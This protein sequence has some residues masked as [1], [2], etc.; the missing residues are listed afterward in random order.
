VIAEQIVADANVADARKAFLAALS[1]K[2]KPINVVVGD[3]IRVSG[4][5][6]DVQDAILLRAGSTSVKDATDTAKG[7]SNRTVIDMGRRYY[8]TLGISGLEDAGNTQIAA[9]LMNPR[10][11]YDR[12]PR[13]AQLAQS[14]GDFSSLLADTINKSLQIGYVEANKT[15][16]IWASRN[17][18]PDFKTITRVDFSDVPGLTARSQGSPITF[19][20]LKDTKETYALQEYTN[21]IK[22]TRQA[23]INDDLGG[24]TKLPQAQAFA[25]ARLE[26]DVAYAILTA[27]AALADGTALIASGH[28]NTVT[29]ASPTLAQFAAMEAAMFKQTGLNGAR[30]ELTGKYILVP[31]EY[32]T[33]AMQLVSSPVDPAKNNATPNL[34]QGYTVVPSAR[35]SAN[36][37]TY[38]YMLADQAQFPTIEVSF[39]QGEETPVLKQQVDF[40]TDDMNFAV[41]HTVAAKA[42]NYRGIVR[43]S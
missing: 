9:M 5:R 36:S 20:T 14:I 28:N 23:I 3:D 8:A 38:Y 13:L 42:L 26:D 31:A 16:N 11:A 33:V 30:L 6:K 39:L 21:G 19:V 7:L 37:T 22:L 43:S 25:A 10:A 17:T 35:L 29:G 41:R 32:R 40:T 1:A 2:S 27:N 15:W 34:Y 18:Y 12:A 24:F 4:M